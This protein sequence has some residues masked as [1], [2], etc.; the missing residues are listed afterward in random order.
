MDLILHIGVSKTGSTAI[1][2]SLHAN[3]GVIGDLYTPDNDD[4]PFVDKGHHKGVAYLANAKRLWGYKN[5]FLMLEYMFEECDPNLIEAVTQKNIS[6]YRE[7]YIGA[8][9]KLVEK[10]KNQDCKTVL[11]ST[12]LLSEVYSPDDVAE[13]CK[14][15][16][17]IFERKQIVVYLRDQVSAYISLYAQNLKGG[18]KFGFDE[19]VKIS[20]AKIAYD[21]DSLIKK[22]EVCGWE[23]V[24]SIFYEKHHAPPEWNILDDFESLVIGRSSGLLRSAVG[25]TNHRHNVSPNADT[26]FLL[27]FFNRMG[28]PG[29]WIRFQQLAL[30]CAK[31][32][33][34]GNDRFL[35]RHEREVEQ[36]VMNHASGNTSIARQFF[37]RE[38]L[39][40]QY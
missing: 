6:K 22:W 34:S 29:K 37:K 14:L 17:P 27:R 31:L 18:A 40:Q 35:K 33:W 13:F 32:C 25:K 19:F 30:R 10:A 2:R 1:Q 21:Y 23:I 36:I 5:G 15:L 7:Q 24:P 8:L 9:K 26:L 20:G 4:L 16:D 11:L 3:S 38:K 28:L 12:E 39:F